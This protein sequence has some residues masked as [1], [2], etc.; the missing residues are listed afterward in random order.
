MA[1]IDSDSQL[2]GPR[3]DIVTE[4]RGLAD[5]DS[6]VPFVLNMEL[7]TTDPF[8]SKLHIRSPSSVESLVPV[9]FH[10]PTNVMFMCEDDDVGV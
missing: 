10:V 8:T 6:L 2:R 3:V 5:P 9:I 7:P 4:K 1:A